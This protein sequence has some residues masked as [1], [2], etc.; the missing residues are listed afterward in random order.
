MGILLHAR[1]LSFTCESGPF[2]DRRGSSAHSD[3][4][5]YGPDC[6]FLQ[7]N[8]LTLCE[9]VGLG[10]EKSL[11]YISDDIGY[12]SLSYSAAHCVKQTN[13][14]TCAL[15]A[16]IRFRRLPWV[17]SWRVPVKLD[18]SPR[19]DRQPWREPRTPWPDDSATVTYRTALT[20]EQFI[21]PKKRF[22]ANVL[23]VTVYVLL[24]NFYLSYV[25]LQSFHSVC[26]DNE[27]QFE[28]SKSSA[29]RNAPVL[30]SAQL[31]D[32]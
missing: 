12:A 5:S 4:P 9:S 22:C 15:F 6:N 26:S 21:L 29:Q 19:I 28:C 8:D 16:D 17:W 23:P 24:T 3:P 7:Q 27:P 1:I 25:G 10:L 2:A 30:H 14:S 13:R 20:H 11:I 18:L 32:I 31:V